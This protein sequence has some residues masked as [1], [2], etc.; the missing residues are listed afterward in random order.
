MAHLPITETLEAKL[1]RVAA[2]YGLSLPRFLEKVA[3]DYWVENPDTS[4]DSSQADPN[5]QEEHSEAIIDREQAEYI[6]QHPELVKKYAG[7]YLAMH[8]GQ[9][10]DHDIDRST[11]KERL[12]AHFGNRTVFV[13]PVLSAP[14]QTLSV[15]GY[16]RVPNIEQA[17]E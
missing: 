5:A 7:Q 4:V 14:I 12:R 6:R 1:Q 10:I 2:Q 11:L 13:T 17:T 16:R 8:N 15:R 3:D 9:V